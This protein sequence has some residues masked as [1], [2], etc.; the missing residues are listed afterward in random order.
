MPAPSNEGA[1]REEEGGATRDLGFRLLR[2]GE[3]R[4][5][6]FALRLVTI[7]YYLAKPVP[8]LDVTHSP[9]LG[10]LV[11]K[12]RRLKGPSDLFGIGFRV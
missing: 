8:G 7:D 12:A 5:E 2:R 10:A 4:E 3:R 6:E 11:D 1:G 9:F